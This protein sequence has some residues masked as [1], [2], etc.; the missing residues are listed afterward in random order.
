MDAAEKSSDHRLNLLLPLIPS[1][2]FA[3]IFYGLIEFIV[4]LQYNDRDIIELAFGLNVHKIAHS[5]GIFAILLLL[6]STQS[7]KSCPANT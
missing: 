1:K 5:S 6:I 4:Q 3:Q 2:N 7:F